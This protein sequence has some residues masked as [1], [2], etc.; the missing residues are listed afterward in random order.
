MFIAYA[1]V[2]KTDPGFYPALVAYMEKL[3][4]DVATV[5]HG[6]NM[7]AAQLYGGNKRP[8]PT[9]SVVAR[10]LQSMGAT[11][12]DLDE[13]LPVADV[14]RRAAEAKSRSKAVSELDR[15]EAIVRQADQGRG[16][17]RGS[18]RKLG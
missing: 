12:R 15:T 4:I 2:A 7:D 5:A 18:K 13:I 1:I 6:A 3:E 9:L 17:K 16:A 10:L 8:N 11:W 14:V